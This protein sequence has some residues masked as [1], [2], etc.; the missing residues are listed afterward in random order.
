MVGRG[1]LLSCSRGVEAFTLLALFAAPLAG[2]ITADGQS[3]VRPA[4]NG[5]IDQVRD[6]DLSLRHS[7]YSEAP[8]RG[9]SSEGAQPASYYGDGTPPIV[10]PRSNVG[11]EAEAAKSSDI[12]GAV[13]TGAEANS[14]NKG[15]DIN[16]ENTPIPTVAKTL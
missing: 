6:L 14:N 13:T 5:I 12:T 10:A 7:R 4:P 2:C 8:A 1:Q 3:G 9:N 11:P 15:Y 16:F